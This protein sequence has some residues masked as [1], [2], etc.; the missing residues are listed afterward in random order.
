MADVFMADEVDEG[1]LKAM[2]RDRI[3]SVW[4]VDRTV[5]YNDGGLA[6]RDLYENDGVTYRGEYCGIQ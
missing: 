5:R 1:K 2:G 6:L 3:Y 4:C